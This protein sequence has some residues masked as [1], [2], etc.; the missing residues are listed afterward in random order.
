VTDGASIGVF[1]LLVAVILILGC[2]P[3]LANAQ[4][5]LSGPGT[6]SYEMDRIVETMEGSGADGENAVGPSGIQT[7]N[8][9]VWF[10]PQGDLSGFEPEESIQ[11]SPGEGEPSLSAG[12]AW[13][14]TG[15]GTPDYAEIYDLSPAQV[16]SSVFERRPYDP[17]YLEIVSEAPNPD[18]SLLGP[19]PEAREEGIEFTDVAADWIWHQKSAGMTELRGHVMIIYDTT[20]ISCDEATLDEGNEIYRFFGEGR[21][22]VDDADFTLECEELEVHDAEEEKM[23]YI[24]GPATMVV[25]A[26]ED[27]EEPGEDATRRDKVEFA[28]KQN[29]TVITFLEGKYDYEND[30]FDASG[31]VRFEQPDKYAQGGEF[32]GENETEYMLFKGDCEFWQQDGNWLYEH[33]IVED[34][35][36]PPSRGDKITRALLSVPTTVTSDE[37][38]FMGDLGWLQLRSEG[39]NVVYFKQDD[40]HGECEI[41]TLYYVDEE[42]EKDEGEGEGEGDA[43]VIEP[44]GP[45]NLIAEPEVIEEPEVVAETEEEEEFVPPPGFGTL[46]LESEYPSDWVPWSEEPIFESKPWYGILPIEFGK[47]LSG[48]GSTEVVE[49][50]VEE[51][52]GEGETLGDIID[53]SQLEGV[54]TEEQRSQLEAMDTDKVRE[55]LGEGGI[56]YLKSL[57]TEEINQLF[58]QYM[59]AE[60]G[61]PEAP[62]DQSMPGAGAPVGMEGSGAAGEEPVGEGVEEEPPGTVAELTDE[63]KVLIYGD[64]NVEPG[65]GREEIIMQGNVFVRQE[66]GDWLFEYDI[67]NEEDEDEETVEQLRKWA[68]GSCDLLHVWTDKEVGEATSRV[69][70]EQDNQNLAS[71]FARYLGKL[72]MAYLHGNIEIHREDKHQLKSNEA[73]FFF[74]T[75]VFEA[76]GA[77]RSTVMVDVEKEGAGEEGI[78][79]SAEAGT[80]EGQAPSEETPPPPP[81]P[82]E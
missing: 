30:I 5:G 23:I 77:V 8:G 44:E 80:E 55:M 7:E 81:P 47:Q 70:G 12:S 54:L 43:E 37:A 13:D 31:D 3:Y 69:Y 38:E 71:D 73:F 25:Y 6:G 65:E 35:E 26:D 42:K 17:Y 58:A 33:K 75:K 36:D 41:F 63:E 74:S 4:I 27:A 53:T 57:T 2:G 72:D 60:T 50:P 19:L 18:I 22:F 11:N 56:E 1:K 82:T 48:T 24:T 20:I 64:L 62:S 10:P 68:N 14:L 16:E 59:G 78:E 76:L 9:V 52:E 40:K 32:H 51:G 67:V 61:G 66:N 28:L 34:K 15:M 21:I 79:E 39:G 46:R 29:D 49:F 45:Q